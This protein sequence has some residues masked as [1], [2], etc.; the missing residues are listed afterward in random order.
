MAHDLHPEYLSTKY[1]L[2]REG[3]DLV[4]V[5]HHHA[6]IVSCLADNGET[7]PVIGVAFDGLGYGDDGTLWGGEILVADLA[8]YQRAGHLVPVPMPGGTAAIKHPW[9]MAASYLDLAFDGVASCG[10][11]VSS[12]ATRTSGGA[13]VALAR[14]GTASPMTSSAGR[15]FDA[16]AAIVCGRD[17]VNYEGQAAIEL[18]QMADPGEM[19]VYPVRVE[20]TGPVLDSR[21]RTGTTCSG[22]HGRRHIAARH[23]RPLPQCSGGK[24]CCCL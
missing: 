12:G 20:G 3:V 18:E 7:G 4:G 22:G 17:S 19:S 15:L 11:S 13:V 16:V 9:R 10:P 2:E 6:H 24:H 21:G 23:S 5:Q 1:A 8:N 14:S